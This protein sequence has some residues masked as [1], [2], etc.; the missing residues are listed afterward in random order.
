MRHEERAAGLGGYRQ[1]G[2]VGALKQIGIRL[3]HVLLHDRPNV[4]VDLPEVAI[5]D[6]RFKRRVAARRQGESD[7]VDNDL[8]RCKEG[9]GGPRV[10]DAFAKRVDNARIVR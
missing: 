6:Q 1:T 8:A 3:Q 7:V 2:R 5:D 10:S 9:A 4:L